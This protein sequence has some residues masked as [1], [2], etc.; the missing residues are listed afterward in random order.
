MSTIIKANYDTDAQA[1]AITLASLASGAARQSSVLDNTSLLYLD[2]LVQ[3]VLKSGVSGVS[4]TGFVNVFAFGTSDAATPTY[5][6]NAGASDAAITLVS[7]TNL[8]LIGSINVVANATTYK[9]NP[10]SVAAAFGGVLPEKWGIVIDNESGAALDST[11]GNHKKVY[12]GLWAQG[13]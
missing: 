8:R 5:G 13:V 7:P 4:A 1:I 12:Q 2:A 9:S 10:M 11:E 6:E 3:L